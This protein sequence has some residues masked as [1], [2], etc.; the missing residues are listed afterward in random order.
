MGPCFIFVLSVFAAYLI[1][2]FPTSYIIGK[3]VRGIDVREAGSGNA[4]A[5]NVLRTVGKTPALVTL[6]VDILKGFLAVT[7][8]SDYFYSLDV[9]FVYEFYRPF[10]GFVAICGH[11]WPVWLKFRGGKGVAATLGVALGLAPL[12]LLPSL[13]IWVAVFAWKHFVSLASIMALVAFP[14]FACIF[15]CSVYTAVFSVAVCAIVVYKHKE[16]IRR[17]VNGVENKTII[18]KKGKP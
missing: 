16:N 1:G 6:I 18:F 2:S 17:L 5:T 14:V 4:G 11:I 13:V 15:G 7:I 9:P 12:A 8:V 3:L 10:I